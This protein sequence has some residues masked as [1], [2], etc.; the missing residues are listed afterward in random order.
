M[1]NASATTPN[2]GGL[3]RLPAVLSLIPVCKATWYAGVK[4]GRYP[5]AVKLSPRV[6]CW[7]AADIQAVVEG[8]SWA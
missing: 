3:L 8:R 7:K 5:P 6:A 4:E 2:A 1:T